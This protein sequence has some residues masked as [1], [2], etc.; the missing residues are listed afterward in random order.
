MKINGILILAV[1]M[2]LSCAPNNDLLNNS[3]SADINDVGNGWKVVWSDDFIDSELDSKKWT[4][5]NGNG[6]WGWGNQELQNYRDENITLEKGSLVITAK[7]ES[8]GNCHYGPCEYTSGKLY[9]KG[10][11]SF[12][13]GKVEAR[14]QPPKGDG[15]WAAFWMLAN[16]NRWPTT[17]EI[18]IMETIGRLPKTA[19]SAVHWG[20]SSSARQSSHEK[21]EADVDLTEDYHVYGVEWSATDI[22]FYIDNNVL[23]SVPVSGTEDD[24]IMN[25]F[26]NDPDN[27]QDEFYL[28]LNLAIGGNF[29]GGTR[30]EASFTESKLYVDWVR[31]SERQ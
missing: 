25:P 3:A 19:S 9:T 26:G 29:D 1:G 17:G 15:M 22:V 5:V 7:K 14:I 27:A 10:N 12:R 30:P 13:Y 16:T 23:L 6:N 18:D 28:I 20:K 24:G 2:L 11:Y 21:R 31:V 4:I 8:I